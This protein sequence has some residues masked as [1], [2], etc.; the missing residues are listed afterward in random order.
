MINFTGSFVQY[1]METT[2]SADESAD[3]T[4]K[5]VVNFPASYIKNYVALSNRPFVGQI[6]PR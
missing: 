4:L 6:Y 1:T 3:S 2:T 5:L